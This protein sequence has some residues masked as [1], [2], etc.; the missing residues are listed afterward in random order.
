LV[1]SKP[2]SVACHPASFLVNQRTVAGPASARG[3]STADVPSGLSNQPASGVASG[4]RW[5]PPGRSRCSHAL[6]SASVS[7]TTAS[8]VDRAVSTVRFRAAETSNGARA[9]ST[10]STGAGSVDSGGTDP[11]TTAFGQLATQTTDAP[12]ATPPSSVHM[13]RLSRPTPMY[14]FDARLSSTAPSAV[15]VTSR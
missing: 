8:V 1:A 6:P 9:S 12:R 3:R 15:A 14:V 11:E 7:T 10:Y 2:L 13:R 4:M 5:L